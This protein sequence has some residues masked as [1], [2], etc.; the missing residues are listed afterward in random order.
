M[1]EIVENKNTVR[2]LRKCFK[3]LTLLYFYMDEKDVIDENT[4]K[5]IK[6]I[7]LDLAPISLI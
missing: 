7:C 2:I 1:I 6:V 3:I 5:I 4:K